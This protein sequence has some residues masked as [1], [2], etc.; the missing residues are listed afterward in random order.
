MDKIKI[1]VGE[2]ELGSSTNS[3]DKAYK[4]TM[5]GKIIIVKKTRQNTISIHWLLPLNLYSAAY[6]WTGGEFMCQPLAYPF[7]YVPGIYL[8][9]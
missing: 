1:L 6:Y 9:H 2:K 3:R 7:K 8:L 5:V 4:D